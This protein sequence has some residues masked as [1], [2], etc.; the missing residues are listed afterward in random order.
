MVWT[1]RGAP[2]PFSAQSVARIRIRSISG[3]LQEGV[4]ID[5]RKIGLGESHFSGSF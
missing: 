1:I 3:F 5:V 2:K 4:R